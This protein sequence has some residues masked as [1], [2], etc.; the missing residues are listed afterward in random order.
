MNVHRKN[1]GVNRGSPFI[2]LAIRFG[3]IKVR[4]NLKTRHVLN[5]FSRLRFNS[6]P[7]QSMHFKRFKD[8]RLRKN[9]CLPCNCIVI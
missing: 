6:K 5:I 1:P 9:T 2:R 4:L 7:W 3:R 8:L